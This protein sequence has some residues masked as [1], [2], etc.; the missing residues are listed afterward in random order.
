[1]VLSWRELQGSACGEV[2]VPL[3][4]QESWDSYVKYKKHSLF[5]NTKLYQSKL[6]SFCCAFEMARYE[7]LLKVQYCI[8][9]MFLEFNLSFSR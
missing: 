4:S 3:R 9:H 6:A 7:I 2:D 1:M 8:L 5:S